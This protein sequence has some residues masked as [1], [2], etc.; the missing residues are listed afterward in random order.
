M[1]T[2]ATQLQPFR[3]GPEPTTIT[4]G[5][6]AAADQYALIPL[7][8]PASV[9]LPPFTPDLVSS[10]DVEAS[11]RRVRDAAGYSSTAP[12]DVA[13]RTR[14]TVAWTALSPEQRAEL[15]A[16][17]AQNVEHGLWSFTLEPDGPGEG[18]VEVCP[19]VH[20][21]DRWVGPIAY[22]VVVDVEEVFV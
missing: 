12:L 21:V 3:Q 8:E 14:W 7:T 6:G 11:V 19:L 1:T 10:V 9:G 2:P 17:L 22:D 16:W 5:S 15:L 4:P 13:R 20:H 18:E